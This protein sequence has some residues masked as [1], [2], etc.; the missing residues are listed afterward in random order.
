MCR[1]THTK[2]KIIPENSVQAREPGQIGRQ[3]QTT[4]GK[5]CAR[6]VARWSVICRPLN[7]PK[8]LQNVAD[9]IDLRNSPVPHYL[10]ALPHHCSWLT[11]S[12]NTWRVGRAPPTSLEHGMY[13]YD[14]NWNVPIRQQYGCHCIGAELSPNQD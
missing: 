2:H 11:K 12:V 10:R 5:G 6:N 1:N 7:H 3:W 4:R 13:Q 9:S 8:H 14:N